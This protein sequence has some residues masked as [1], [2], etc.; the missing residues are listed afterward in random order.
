MF[1]SHLQVPVTEYNLGAFDGEVSLTADVLERQELT[2]MH[3]FLCISV[4]FIDESW[5]LRKWA[6][7]C[8][9]IDDV[10]GVE[11]LDA[12]IKSLDE[13]EIRDKT[14]SLTLDFEYEAEEFDNIKRHVQEKKKLS[15][16]GQLFRVNCC[17]ECVSLVVRAAFNE[18]R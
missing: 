16:N 6:I 17:A 18:I 1:D 9:S 12:I 13:W 10:F 4:H 14:S 5:I 7:K 11:T 3:R 15:L 2:G 8:C